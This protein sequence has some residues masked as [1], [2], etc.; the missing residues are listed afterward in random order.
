MQL[1]MNGLTL[2]FC[3]SNFDSCEKEI[4]IH[5]P[6]RLSRPGML[7]ARLSIDWASPITYLERS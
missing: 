5:F 2:S 6:A 4:P 3:G 7:L 1:G